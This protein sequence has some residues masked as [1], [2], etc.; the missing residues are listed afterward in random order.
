LNKSKDI[1]GGEI[2]YV[3]H[4]VMC[5]IQF[6]LKVETTGILKNNKKKRLEYINLLANIL[7]HIDDEIIM[8]QK[9]C[10]IEHKL[11]ALSL[12]HQLTLSNLFKSTTS[13]FGELFYKGEKILSKNDHMLRINKIKIN[14]NQL[15]IDGL[16]QT[17][18]PPKYWNLSLNLGKQTILL[19]PKCVNVRATSILDDTL[20]NSYYFKQKLELDNNNNKGLFTLKIGDMIFRLKIRFI[21]GQSSQFLCSENKIFLFKTKYFKILKNSFRKRFKLNTLYFLRLLKRKKIKV[22]IF[23]L[24]YLFLKTFKRKEIW[25]FSDR[26]NSGGDNGEILFEYATKQMNNSR[27]YFLINKI[28]PDRSRIKKYGKVLDFNTIRYKLIFLL[29]DK[30]ISS[31]ATNDNLN[32]FG[33]HR[34]YYYDLYNFDFIFLQHGVMSHDLSWWLNKPA[35]NIDLFITSTKPEHESILNYEYLYEPEEVVLTG[36]PRFDRLQNNTENEILIMPTWRSNLALPR[37]EYGLREKNPAFKES[38]YYYFYN[39]LINNTKLVENLKEL[40]YKVVL[41]LHP[42]F[43]QYAEDFDENSESRVDREVCNYSKAFSKGCLLVTDYSS[44]VFDFAY[45]R[46]PVIYSQFDRETFYQNH[47]FTQTYLD[48]E[49]DGFGPVCYDLENT[50]NTIIEML[51]NRCKLGE[52]YKNR[53]EETFKYDDRNNSKRVYEAIRELDR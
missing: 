3:Q 43:I 30:I 17:P 16:F 52:K 2:K 13:V 46:K 20:E 26:L 25:I 36:L 44:T 32:P 37:N 10:S 42:E 34:R 31:Q 47:N 48:F 23:R 7:S 49:R 38:D 22:L 33:K 50:V 40:G 18:L 5:D 9:F 45:L 21:K 24:A 29:A 8:A 11:Y 35:K 51:K 28:S 27:K 39:S 1:Y 53:I 19:N 6:R 14:K 15:E 41:H 12:K 4:L